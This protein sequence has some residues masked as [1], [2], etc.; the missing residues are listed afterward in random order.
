MIFHYRFLNMAKDI[1][2]REISNRFCDGEI[3]GDLTLENHYDFS[4]EELIFILK[5]KG[6]EI[7]RIGISKRYFYDEERNS[8]EMFEKIVEYLT[9]NIN[10][11]LLREEI[12]LLEGKEKEDVPT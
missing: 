4:K 1:A 2:L 5:I 6:K 9:L 11:K 3:I 10:F 7:R 12:N 8:G